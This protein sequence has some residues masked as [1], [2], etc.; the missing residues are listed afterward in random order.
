[1]TSPDRR[2][3]MKM[4]PPMTCSWISTRPPGHRSSSRTGRPVKPCKR[5]RPDCIRKPQAFDR[6]YQSINWDELRQDDPG[7]YAARMQE[8]QDRRATFE[9]RFK[10][11]QSHARE[12]EQGE[13]AR[14]QE[15]MAEH[16][17]RE[18][19]ACRR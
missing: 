8:F 12:F 15:V 2:Q 11:F 16:L 4:N 5:G 13:Q 10:D 7:E 9:T 18:R 3:V 17:A 19:A 6:D 1:M 14:Y